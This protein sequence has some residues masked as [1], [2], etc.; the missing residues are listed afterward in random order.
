[1]VTV[2]IIGAGKSSSYLIETLL[3]YTIKKS[4]GWRVIVA[5]ADEATLKRKTEKYPLAEI[6]VLD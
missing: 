5:D 4:G 3:Q 1:M 2:L 6:A